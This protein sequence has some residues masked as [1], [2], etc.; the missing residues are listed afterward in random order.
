MLEEKPEVSH[1]KPR[2][3]LKKKKIEV[4]TKGVLT[5]E[6]N[7]VEFTKE[8]QEKIKE[9]IN[10][11]LGEDKQVEVNLEIKKVSLGNKN[12]TLEKEEPK[13][14]FRNYS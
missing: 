6:V 3:S 4:S 5:A 10:T 9:K 1:I 13:V 12:K 8:I 7:L 2:V 14:P 11:L